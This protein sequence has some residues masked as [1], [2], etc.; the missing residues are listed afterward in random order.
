MNAIDIVFL[1]LFLWAAWKGFKRGLV[2][3]LAS[4]AALVLGIYAALNFSTYAAG[5]LEKYV[6]MD[7]YWLNIL[8]FSLTFLLVMV[9]VIFLGKML[10]KVVKLVMLG[11]I[12]KL[13]GLVFSVL[14]TA[15]V[16]SVLIFLFNLID[17]DKRIYP[18]EKRQ[19][20]R[21][22]APVEALVPELLQRIDLPQA[23][24]SLPEKEGEREGF[25]QAIEAR[26]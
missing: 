19:D 26:L 1:I 15:M 12:N 8:S 10:E 21:L 2:I 25:Q 4:L 9:A 18:E 17:H 13:L 23:P 11:L 6:E 5:V 22:F 3:E 24:F 20:S 7:P 14:K 16:L